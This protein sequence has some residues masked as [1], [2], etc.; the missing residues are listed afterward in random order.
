MRS[1]DFFKRRDMNIDIGFRCALE[2]PRCARWRHYRKYG[3]KVPG[4]DITMEEYLKVIDWCYKHINFSGQ[5]SDPIH[6]PLLI[7]F[8]KV[9]YERNIETSVHNASSSKSKEWYIKAFKANPN[10]RWIFGIDGMPEES[11]IYRIN[12]KGQKLYDIMLEAKKHL[13]RTPVWQYIIFSYNEHN[14][15]K[16]MKKAK[17]DGVVFMYLQSSRWDSDDDELMPKNKKYKMSKK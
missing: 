12:Q 8:L 11:H 10:A 4:Y 7:D 3:N 6:H 16:A 14:L 5:Y 2:C 15:D 1:L 13:N 9:N 17:K